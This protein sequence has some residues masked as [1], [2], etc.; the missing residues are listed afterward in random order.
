MGYEI[1]LSMDLLNQGVASTSE[2]STSPPTDNN[3]WTDEI[4]AILKKWGEESKGLTWMHTRCDKWFNFWDKMIGLPAGILAIILSLAIFATYENVLGVKIALGITS[5]IVGS[6]TFTQNYFNW[7]KRSARHGEA[8]IQYQAYADDIEAELALDR[9]TRQPG[10]RYYKLI[11]QRRFIL[12]S[13]DYPPIIDRYIELYKEKLYNTTIS[14]P[15]IADS[16]TEIHI[17]KDDTKDD[18]EKSILDSV[19]IDRIVDLEKRNPSV[20]YELSRYHHHDVE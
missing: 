2:S 9:T 12:L 20:Q 15:V 14:R 13:A 18:K 11:K 1:K 10:K 4:E 16:I 3:D 5:F 8:M 17:N 7:G 19:V 6:L